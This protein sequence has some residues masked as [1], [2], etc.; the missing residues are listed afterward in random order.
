MRKFIFL[1]FLFSFCC[2]F[3]QNEIKIYPS[4]WWVGMK[5]QNLQ[6]MISWE[7]HWMSNRHIPSQ[8]IIRES[9]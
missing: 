5:N 2:A 4:N 6:L 1:P 7:H 8:L 3:A 9:E